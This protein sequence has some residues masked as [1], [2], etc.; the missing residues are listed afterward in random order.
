MRKLIWLALAIGAAELLKRHANKRGL[1]VPALLSTIAASTAA[2]ITA[3]EP[4][5]SSKA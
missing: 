1:T 3:T 2:R 4:E 5:P